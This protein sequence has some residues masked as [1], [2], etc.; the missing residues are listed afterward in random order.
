MVGRNFHDPI[1]TELVRE[2]LRSN[3]D[4]KV[5]YSKIL[6]ARANLLGAE[7]NLAP[8]INGIGSF[9][10]NESSL[11]SS[12]FLN[13]QN[14]TSGVPSSG[15]ASGTGTTIARDRYFNFY[16]LGLNTAWE[17]DLFGRIR[18]EGR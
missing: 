3:Y 4:L 7:A 12:Q 11:N 15:T 10:H 16:Q 14:V 8:Q 2:T 1:L 17:I 6:A 5:A 13:Q 9:S 18:K